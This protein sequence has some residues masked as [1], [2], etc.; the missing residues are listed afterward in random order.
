MELLCDIWD[1]ATKLPGL[2]L[3]HECMAKGALKLPKSISKDCIVCN[4]IVEK[5][6]VQCLVLYQSS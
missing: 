2:Y 4:V 3:G 5:N 1:V 6:G